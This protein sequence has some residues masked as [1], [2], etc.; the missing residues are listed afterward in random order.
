MNKH[1]HILALQAVV[2]ASLL[3]GL[4]PAAHGQNGFNM[5]YSQF[6]M[7]ST[8]LPYNLPIVARMGGTTYTRSGNNYVNPF[9]PASYGTVE[10]ESFVF[11]MGVGI[12]TST[13]RDDHD[14]MLDADGN[15]AYL[16]MAMPLTK[17]WKLGAGLLPYTTVSYESV[18]LGVD[19]TYPDTVKTIYDGNG[20]L[21]QAFV[22]MAF[23]VLR[24]DGHRPDVQ[25]GFN[26]NYLTG[27]V[28]RAI[29]YTFMHD[30]N[31]YFLP[32]RHYKHTTMGNFTFDLG[33]QARQPLGERYTLGLGLVYKPYMDLKVKDMAL[34]YTYHAL[35]ES[36]V[37]TV[38][39]QRGSSPEF[40]SRAEQA[41]TFGVGLSLERNKRWLAAI[42]AT[43]ADWQGLRY[44]EGSGASLFGTS[45]VGYGPYRRLAAGFEKIGD[46]DAPTYWGRMSWS[47]GLHRETG[48]LYFTPAGATALERVDEWG[49]GLGVTMPMRKGRSLLTLSLGYSSLGSRSVLQRNSLTF[50]IAVSSCEHWFFKRKYN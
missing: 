19:P 3:L 42:D 35:D 47:L 29:S 48:V 12:Q 23:N 27:H 18:S 25:V 21:S 7:G 50:G 32:K 44:T 39:P 46:M 2:C 14:R 8:E 28:D 40:D 6:G 33:L 9:N 43:F 17:W 38:F 24:G 49:G 10:Q 30:T 37:D 22:G 16:L 36:L 15:V 31:S 41:H 34:V 5:P 4:H 11:D 45:S 26:L 13:L 20:G 1:R